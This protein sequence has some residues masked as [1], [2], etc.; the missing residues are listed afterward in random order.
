VTFSEPGTYPLRAVASDG[1]IFTYG[2]VT[3]T[4]TP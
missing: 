2:D 3:V 1:S 4:V